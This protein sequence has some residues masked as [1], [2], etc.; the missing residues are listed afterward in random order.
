MS[1]NEV[2]Q[3][4]QQG[5]KALQYNGIRAANEG[6]R[7]TRVSS[8]ELLLLLGFPAEAVNIYRRLSVRPP[9]WWANQLE[10][11]AGFCQGLAATIQQREE[12]EDCSELLTLSS[13]EMAA[14]PRDSVQ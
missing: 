12:L 4:V 10:L 13:G 3:K 1:E 2:G 7:L 6:K 9:A 5:I 8:Q 11:E 14:L